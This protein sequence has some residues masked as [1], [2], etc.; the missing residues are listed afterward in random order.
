MNKV[1]VAIRRIGNG[2]AI[3]CALLTTALVIAGAAVYF[4]W[5]ERLSH[6]KTASV[7]ESR[8]HAFSDDPHDPTEGE[9]RP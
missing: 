3:A 5:V 8:V 7:S 1:S 9:G 4:T 6:R 2:I